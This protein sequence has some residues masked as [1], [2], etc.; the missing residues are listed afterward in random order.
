VTE[1][2]QRRP[3]IASAP[4][5]LDFGGGWTDVP[6]FPE[7]RGGFVCNLAIE[8]RA[9]ATLVGGSPDGVDPATEIESS[10]LVAAALRR[11]ARDGVNPSVHI[12]LHSDFPVGAGLG[13][14]SAAGVALAAV[15]SAHGNQPRTAAML[16]EWSR[17]V[18]VEELGVAGGRQDHYAAAFG[19]ALG[20]TF[21]ATTLV[22]QIPLT[23]DTIAALEER[24]LLVYTGESRISGTTISAVLD[25]YRDRVPRIVGAL[26][27]MKALARQMRDA[28]A[29]GDLEALSACVDEHWAHQ[30]AL[31]AG[32]TT[33]RIDAI[34]QA[35]RGA[36]ASGLKA[37]GASGGGC[38]IVLAPTDRV[39]AVRAAVSPLGELLPWRVA[40]EGVRLESAGGSAAEARG[41]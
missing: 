35:A 1:P 30:R 34:A 10:A 16:A 18:E 37:L 6:P 14:S 32:I 2:R 33:A 5:R 15:L 39:A 41:A 40:T 19:G 12:T 25:A 11:A 29:V 23:A 38:V 31:H 36:G 17:A 9:T 24:C 4:T 26:D 27:R 28:L 13:G 21:E 20:L 7:E 22:E 3:R 8:R